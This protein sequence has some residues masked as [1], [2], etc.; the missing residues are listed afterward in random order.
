MSRHKVL[1]CRGTGC[2]AGGSAELFRTLQA[3]VERQ[4]LSGV[5][6]DYTGCHGFCEQGPIVVVEPEGIF[7]TEVQVEDL[8]EIVHS[9]LRGANRWRGFSMS[10]PSLGGRCRAMRRS[11]FTGS[12]S[13]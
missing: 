11:I 12:N 2:Q 8:P 6:V 9:H 1:I 4:G 10:I 13:G 7:Y 3:E 5:T